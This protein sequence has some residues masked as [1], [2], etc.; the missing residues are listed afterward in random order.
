MQTAKRAALP[1]EAKIVL[2]EVHADPKLSEVALTISLSEKASGI[3]K[4]PRLN[5][6]HARYRGDLDSN[7][8]S[9]VL[10]P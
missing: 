7:S 1:V 8:H 3:V 9:N 10:I 4:T 2:N 6:Q 5:D